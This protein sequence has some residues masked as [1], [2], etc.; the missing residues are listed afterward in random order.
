MYEYKATVVRIVDG[1]T[2]DV[3]IN[4]G[5]DVILRKQRIRLLG[6]DTPEKRTRDPIEKIFGLLASEFVENRIPVGTEII[7]KT[8]LRDR[9]KF[10]RILGDIILENGHSLNEILI[11]HYYAV[12]YTGQ[13][14]DLIEA[15]HL[16]NRKILIDSGRVTLP[17]DLT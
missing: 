17:E 6:V 13:S 1:D 9:G 15:K 14:K 11:N 4:L 12:H 16:A 8:Q 10:G 3:D 7:I 2:I 5:F